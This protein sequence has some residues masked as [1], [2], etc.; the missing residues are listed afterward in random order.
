MPPPPE[1]AAAQRTRAIATELA[2]WKS[3]VAPY[4]QPSSR[5]AAWQLANTIGPFLALWAGMYA[6]YPHSTLA[7]VALGV[8]AS[9]FLVRVFIIQHDCGHYSF[10]RK[11]KVND[12]IGFVCSFFSSIPYTYWAR[13][14]SFHHGHTGQLEHR[15][16][17]DIDFLTVEE[18]RQLGKWGRFKYRAFRHPLV[19]FVIVPIIYL[20]VMLRLPKITFAGWRTVHVKQH[21]NNILIAVVYIGLGFLL[22]WKAFLIVQGS[23]IFFF[24][25]IAFWFFYVQHQHEHTYM[26]WT[27]NWDYLTAAIKGATF[28]KLPR[29]LHFLTGNIGYHHIHHLSSRIPNY[30]LR[31]CAKENPI[32]QKYVT[33]ISFFQSLPMMFN[34]LWDEEKQRMISFREFYRSEAKMRMA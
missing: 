26:Q 34:K 19:L 22:G 7:T 29:V 31:K 20:G 8:L 17:G 18:Y 24:G 23:I 1:S 27:K 3:I 33:K 4:Q 9:F 13:V 2:D 15:D 32:L 14:H 12:A 5:R 16:I 11:R 10:L 30:N 21:V 6:V 25:I 28:Y